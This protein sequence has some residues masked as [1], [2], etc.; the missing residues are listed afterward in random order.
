M[1][2]KNATKQT[3]FYLTAGPDLQSRVVSALPS[4]FCPVLLYRLAIPPDVRYNNGTD[5]GIISRIASSAQTLP[6]RNMHAMAHP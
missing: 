5:V 2:E 6:E 4:G 3:A 1:D